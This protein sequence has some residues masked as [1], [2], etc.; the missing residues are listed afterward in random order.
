LSEPGFLGFKDWHDKKK[1]DDGSYRRRYH[2]KTVLRSMP[3]RGY[4]FVEKTTT[5]YIARQLAGLP[6]GRLVAN[7]ALYSARRG[8]G[9]QVSGHSR[10]KWHTSDSG[11]ITGMVFIQ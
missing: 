2:L 5:P 3:H 9:D 8:T 11:E 10:P 6:T 7:F 4:L 1:V